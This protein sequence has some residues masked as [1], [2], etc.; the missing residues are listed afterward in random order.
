MGRDSAVADPRGNGADRSVR[1]SS[2]YFV[3]GKS[4]SEIYIKGIFAEEGVADGATDYM[5]ISVSSECV[6]NMSERGALTEH[7][8]RLLCAIRI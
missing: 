4:R 1:Q 2:I 7:P 3:R 8:Q 6:Q 5:H